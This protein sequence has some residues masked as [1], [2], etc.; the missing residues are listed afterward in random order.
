MNNAHL[1]AGDEHDS[2]GDR[3]RRRRGRRPNARDGVRE[4]R[5]RLARA[6]RKPFVVRWLRYLRLSALG[7]LALYPAFLLV[8][9]VPTK[10]VLLAALGVVTAG[11][12]SIPK[13]RLYDA[14]GP[15]SGAAMAFGSVAG[16]IGGVFPLAIGVVASKF[17]LG[18]AMWLLI[19]A[20]VALLLFVPRR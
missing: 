2:L 19:A 6:F 9:G 13:A 11:W 20:P 7:A 18:A 17:G 8:P 4:H 10:L 16:L 15:Q 5:S 12:Y 1:E 3:G 14:L